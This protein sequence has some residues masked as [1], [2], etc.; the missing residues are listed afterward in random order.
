MVSGKVVTFEVEL[1][2]ETDFI[3]GDYIQ[4]LKELSNFKVV[5]YKK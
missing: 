1:D 5:N 2:N 4:N 3:V